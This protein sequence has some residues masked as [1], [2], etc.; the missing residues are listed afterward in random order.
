MKGRELPYI[1]IG[2]GGHAKVLINTL[3][4]QNKKILG[5]ISL[6]KYAKILSVPVIGD[7]QYLL[8]N[9]QPNKVQLVNGIGSIHKPTLRKKIFQTYKEHGY[10]FATVIHPSVILPTRYLLEEGVQLMAG[11]ILQP[12]VTI[13]ENSIINTGV[14]I[15]HDCK[16]CA[17]V[18]LAPGVTLSGNVII[19][20]NCHIGTAATVIQGICIEENCIIGAGS[21][22]LKHIKPNQLAIGV[23]A[24]ETDIL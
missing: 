14:S 7:D 13:G 19:K 8:A 22:I 18:H 9:H 3:Q 15:D 10:H 12:D 20:D 2:S 6:D 4:L 1:I 16:I 21:L 23:P 11:S 5:C 17:N 24:K